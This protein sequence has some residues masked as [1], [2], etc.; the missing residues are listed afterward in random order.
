MRVLAI[1]PGYGRM[2]VA[3][4]DK[5]SGEDILVYSNCVETDKALTLPERLMALAQAVERLLKEYKPSFV[6]LE[7]LFFNKNQKTAMAVAEARGLLIYL[8]IKY[9]AKVREF[10]PQEI[11]VAV[12]GYGKSDK[13]P[14]RIR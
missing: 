8:A 2:G 10:G 4:L 13:S 7:K 1:D 14:K 11:K 12:T 3:V 5:I 9:G 6:A